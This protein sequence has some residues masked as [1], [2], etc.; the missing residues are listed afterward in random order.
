M[1]PVCLSLFSHCFSMTK[2]LAMHSFPGL[3]ISVGCLILL[4]CF[5]LVGGHAE[6]ARVGCPLPAASSQWSN[7]GNACP[8][9]TGTRRAQHPLLSMHRC[10]HLPGGCI[11]ITPRLGQKHPG[12]VGATLAEA[13][14]HSFTCQKR[15]DLSK[16]K[17]SSTLGRVCYCPGD[18]MP[19]IYW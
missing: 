11:C 1:L 15:S 4:L 17:R 7:L 3:K 12:A 18:Q 5:L 6:I 16:F 19:L 14:S 8:V 9:C 13:P 10:Q 2:C